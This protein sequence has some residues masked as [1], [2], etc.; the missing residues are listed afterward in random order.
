MASETRVDDDENGWNRDMEL[1]DE[2][3]V[4]AL[5]LSNDAFGATL[6]M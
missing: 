4:E 5:E 1:A 3:S 2:I 6:L